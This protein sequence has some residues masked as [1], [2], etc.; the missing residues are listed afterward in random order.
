MKNN[1]IKT[2]QPK[3]PNLNISRQ[4][5]AA[6]VQETAEVESQEATPQLDGLAI[7]RVLENPRA[8]TP[9]NILRMHNL[10]GNRA[11]GRLLANRPTHA[12]IIQRVLAD[13]TPSA[14]NINDTTKR[15]EIKTH[16]GDTFINEARLIGSM[17]QFYE[18]K[19]KS[20][21]D[22]GTTFLT[23]LKDLAK[24]LKDNST[25]FDIDQNIA[26]IKSLVAVSNIW[27]GLAGLTDFYKD[28][29]K[30]L[31]TY[32]EGE[33]SKRSN[34][35]T[36]TVKEAYNAW[37]KEFVQFSNA[38]TGNI[39]GKIAAFATFSGSE[40]KGQTEFSDFSFNDAV[41]GVNQ[42]ETLAESEIAWKNEFFFPKVRSKLG[43]PSGTGQQ[44][45]TGDVSYND[46]YNWHI[47]VAFNT[48][49]GGKQ[50]V[51]INKLHLSF[52]H[53]NNGGDK[54]VWFTPSGR[55]LNIDN[56]HGGGPTQTQIDFAKNQVKNWAETYPKFEIGF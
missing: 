1:S 48:V 8:T 42:A 51:K 31:Q 14:P 17:I 26:R 36:E 30:K 54:S 39:Q 16:A 52:K 5:E 35:M 23:E 47:S 11:V 27:G 55:T 22:D 19:F 32:T 4:T 7:R 13:Y 40:G 43:L 37:K 6:Q 21:S 53:K 12:P 45:Y 33:L 34:R 2:R 50:T 3:Q 29:F 10:I 44:L 18:R 49:S 46:T 9:N 28:R 15:T 38:T 24:D 25:T 56:T 20:G 41:N